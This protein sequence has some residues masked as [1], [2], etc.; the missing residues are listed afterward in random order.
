MNQITRRSAVELL[1]TATTLPARTTA[2][3]TGRTAD[4]IMKLLDESW[5]IPANVCLNTGPMGDGSLVPEKEATLLQI[6]HRQGVRLVTFPDR[7]V[8]LA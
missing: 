5:T 3:P 2:V 4:E 1:A 8:T 6:G 7:F